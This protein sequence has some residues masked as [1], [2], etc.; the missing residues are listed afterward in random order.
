M[1][2]CVTP[3]LRVVWA[4]KALLAHPSHNLGFL[5]TSDL[6]VAFT[7]P[8]QV[9]G[10]CLNTTQVF[11]TAET[12]AMSPKHHIAHVG[13]TKELPKGLQEAAGKGEGHS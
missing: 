9:T 12:M 8:K 5:P 10:A 4:A 3:A 2:I 7:K 13:T 6:M 1:D 11:S